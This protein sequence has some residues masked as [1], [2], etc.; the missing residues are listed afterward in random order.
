[1]AN[2]RGNRGSEPKYG[3]SPFG[4]EDLEVYKKARDLRQELYK[5]IRTLP[6]DEKFALGVQMRRA[7]VSITNNIAEAYGRFHWQESIHFCQ[8]ARGSLL[9]SVDDLNVC[10]DNGYACVE[11]VRALRSSAAE[12]LRL[13]N[14]YIHYLETSKKQ[15]NTSR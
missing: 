10:Q 15:Q 8:I 9:E 14:G 12:V 2:V 5:L 11:T 1:M 4:F 13:L 3:D 6:A 7:A